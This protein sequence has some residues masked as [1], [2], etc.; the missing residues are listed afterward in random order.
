[1]SVRDSLPK[2]RASSSHYFLTF[3]RGE[4]LRCFAIRPWAFYSLIG[5]MPLALSLY[6][7]ATL[8]YIYRDDMLAALMSRQTEMQYAYEDRLA[9]MR[10]QIDRVTGR[11]LLD[12]NSLE[13]RVHEL[14]SRQ[15]QI[16]SRATVIAAL[17]QQAGV[18]V[19]ATSSIAK[20]ADARSAIGR[21]TNP[22]LGGSMLGPLPSG[23]AAFAPVP[24]A[25][26]PAAAEKP[27]PETFEQ[28]S[29]NEPAVDPALE[30]AANP[31]VPVETRLRSLSGSLQRLE[32]AQIRAVDV[33]GGAARR[34]VSRLR[35]AMQDAG[36][37]VD[38][39]LAS[40]SAGNGKNVGGP[41]VP[42]NAD[43]TGSPFER[44]VFT[45]QNDFIAAARLTSLVRHSPL[46]KPLVG[47]LE[48]TSPFGSRVDLF[49]GR[50]A[51]H[52]GVDLR[53]TTGA[54]ARATAAGKV[55]SAGWA[56]GYGNMVEIDHGNGLTTRY[57][58]L[59][60]IAVEEGQTVAARD[61]IGRV[62]STGRSTGPHLHYEVRVDDTPVDP[63][64]FLR[65][66]EKLAAND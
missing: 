37:P 27:R 28:R 21:A 38:R 24:S 32:L 31:D 43:P 61:I 49:F 8:Y 63:M 6:L 34:S 22:L 14:L 47:K 20:P 11:Q 52:T 42:L 56:G 44:E 25:S 7:G 29:S 41:F 30:I 3:S 59:S 17:A 62:G 39:L 51:T 9:A 64:R 65:A 19:D 35:G 15:A 2:A 10:A 60:S 40:A 50:L 18:S 16:E 58:H 48:I 12:Q 13:G 36:L 57:G 46:R 53:E 23:A 1:M 33:V 66:G 5:A 4:N 26:H 54:P 45:L 55:V